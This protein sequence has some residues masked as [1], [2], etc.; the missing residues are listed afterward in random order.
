M[1][2]TC[3][4]GKLEFDNSI[5]LSMA[6]LIRDTV[7]GQILSPSEGSQ[8]LKRDEGRIFQFVAEAFKK[9]AS[10]LTAIYLA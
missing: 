2:L 10:K 4:I 7:M 3:T 9:D 8:R 5:T 1:T 6:K